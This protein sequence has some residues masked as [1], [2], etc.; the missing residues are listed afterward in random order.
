MQRDHRILRGRARELRDQI[1]ERYNPTWGSVF[2]EGGS[3]SLY[4]SQVRT[5]SCVYT[6]RVSNFVA[7]GT[8]HYFRVLEDPMAHD[9]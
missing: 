5:Y 3:Q 7:Y 4:G 9:L 8:Q 2:Q 1:A 6:S